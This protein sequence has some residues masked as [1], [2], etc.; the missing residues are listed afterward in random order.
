[1]SKSRTYEEAP[2]EDA[3]V[4]SVGLEGKK[5]LRASEVK[6]DRKCIISNGQQE[7]PV[8]VCCKTCTW[9]MMCKKTMGMG[10]F[11]PVEH[12]HYLLTSKPGPAR[13]PWSTCRRNSSLTFRK[14]AGA[15]LSLTCADGAGS[16]GESQ[17][18]GRRWRQC[19][20]MWSEQ[21]RGPLE[22]CSWLHVRLL[23]PGERLDD[24]LP[25]AGRYQRVGVAQDLPPVGGIKP[26]T[27]S[28]HT[29]SSRSSWGASDCPTF[30][31][32]V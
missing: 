3:A 8:L 7:S 29:H 17:S 18:T 11:D 4:R 1:M 30:H 16:E 27:I 23:S 14:P 20:P 9:L 5:S 6:P 22:L 32:F 12:R 15:R 21:Q 24:R 19:V 31:S 26:V 2:R 10:Q 28:C 13:Q 25:A